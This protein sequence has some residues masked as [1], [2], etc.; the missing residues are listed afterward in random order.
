M[1]YKKDVTKT[2]QQIRKKSAK[3]TN[4]T[5]KATTKPSKEEIIPDELEVVEEEKEPV[6]EPVEVI[7]SPNRVNCSL[8]TRTDLTIDQ[9]K[10]IELFASGMTITDI[11]RTLKVSKTQIYEWKNKCPAFKEELERAVDDVIFNCKM[12]LATKT[13]YYISEMEN[14]YRTTQNEKLK[15][16]ILQELLS[17]TIDKGNVIKEDKVTKKANLNIN[18]NVNNLDN[19]MLSKLLDK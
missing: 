17:Y 4:T 5:K 2:M 15:F 18:A 1:T 12:N 9:I 14:L 19:D 16:Q 11:T 13:D 3:K 10:V 6:D 7:V 8:A